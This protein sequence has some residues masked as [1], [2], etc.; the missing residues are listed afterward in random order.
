MPDR[1]QGARDGLGPTPGCPTTTWLCAR[2][3]A[4][5]SRRAARR[6]SG[7]PACPRR[8]RPTAV[9]CANDLLALG[10]LQQA[11]GRGLRVPDD[12]AIVGYDDIEFAAARPC[13]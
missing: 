12:L 6:A 5:P 10:L 3:R 11:I 4:S 1:L 2:D 7:W 8:R 9:F 13:R